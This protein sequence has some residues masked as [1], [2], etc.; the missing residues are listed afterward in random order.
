MKLASQIFGWVYVAYALLSA[1]VAL[2]TLQAADPGYVTKRSYHET[3]T[4]LDGFGKRVD[5][6][7]EGTVV[8]IS[9]EYFIE[10]W[11]TDDC[12]Y[13]D[14]FEERELPKIKKAGVRYKVFNTAMFPPPDEMK[15]APCIRV[16]RQDMLIKQF[17]GFVKADKV[18]EL[19]VT[20]ARLLT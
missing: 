18:L 5:Q 16:F 20:K 13:C 14:Q 8:D 9:T 1:Y 11:V 10:I 2:D 7:D 17:N 6:P 4:S 15:S 12:Q 19:L 3:F